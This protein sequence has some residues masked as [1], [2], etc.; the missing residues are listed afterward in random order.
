MKKLLLMAAALLISS[1]AFALELKSKDIDEGG[2]LKDTQVFDSFGCKGK[3]LSPH[4]SWTGAPEATKS[5]AVNVYDPDAPTGSGWWHW[6]VFNIPATSTELPAGIGKLTN[7]RL[8]GNAIS[9]R[10]DYGAGGFG[11]ACPPAGDK[12]HRY[13]FTVYALKVEA[14]PLDVDATPAMAGFNINANTLAKASI[15]ATYGR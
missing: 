11:G 4:L 14:L 8:P 6:V 9:S 2:T 7:A 12:P 1:N 13:I 15:T 3:N 5:F 10:N